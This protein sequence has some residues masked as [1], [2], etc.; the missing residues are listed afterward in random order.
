MGRPF[1]SI[2]SS[3][4]SDHFIL[5]ISDQGMPVNAE[6]R[7]AR[8][9]SG[10][11]HGVFDDFCSSSEVSL[12]RVDAPIPFPI[13]YLEAKIQYRDENETEKNAKI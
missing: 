7:K 5:L 12:S 3:R 9:K 1:S 10:S 6:N 13:L 2:P 4:T 11:L 8:F